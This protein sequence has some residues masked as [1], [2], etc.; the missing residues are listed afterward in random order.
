[1]STTNTT[2]ILRP[3]FK[4]ELKQNNQSVLE[5]FEACKKSQSEFI[6]TRIDDHVFIKFPK[7]EQHFW[8]PQLH[9]ELNEI[10]Q[11]SC[12]L[13]GLFGPNPT[14]WTLFLFLHFIVAALFLSF[15]IWAYSNYVLNTD[16]T[17][18]IA[19]MIFM[20]IIWFALYFAGR[21]GRNA[22]KNDMHKLNDF[23]HRVIDK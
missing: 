23:M 16:Y 15:G 11:N 21:L 8:S 18:Q 20:V 14:V 5:A 6:I 2:I 17:L 13:H 10:N 12:T 9:L 1:M 4:M 22:S 3:R 7:A 19:L